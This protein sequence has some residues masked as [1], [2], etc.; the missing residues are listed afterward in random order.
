V[1]ETFGRFLA[2]RRKA[3]GLRPAELARRIGV[4]PKYLSYLERGTDPSGIS[5]TLRPTTELADAI[6]S[7]LGIPATEV[8]CAAG[9][10]T[11]DGPEKSSECE[12][13]TRNGFTESEFAVLFEKY[14][15]LTPE[16]RQSFRPI[17]DMI[18]HELERLKKI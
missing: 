14:E 10:I 13:S 17:L 15:A 12:E 1:K 4:T 18:D 2:R 9:L 16:Q 6:A 7:A 5:D 3:A 8:R 11:P